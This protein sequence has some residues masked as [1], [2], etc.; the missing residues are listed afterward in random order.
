[1]GAN[2]IFYLVK[3]S[4]LGY[5]QATWETSETVREVTIHLY[6]RITS[7]SRYVVGSLED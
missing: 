5:D 3:W 1:M 7:H 2:E 4:F 6:F